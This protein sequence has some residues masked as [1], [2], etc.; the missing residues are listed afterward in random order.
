ML[1]ARV[2]SPKLDY[3]LTRIG[4]FWNQSCHIPLS[5]F[6]PDISLSRFNTSLGSCSPITAAIMAG[7]KSSTLGKL[8]PL[9]PASLGESCKERFAVELLAPDSPSPT[10]RF[11]VGWL[12][13]ILCCGVCCGVLDVFNVVDD[14]TSTR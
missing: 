4:T 9:G 8:R 10:L 7:S 12:S 14:A 1:I 2:E 5:V 11:L 6:P 13:A 3:K